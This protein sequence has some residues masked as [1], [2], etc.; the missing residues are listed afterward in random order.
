MWLSVSSKIP[1]VLGP[2]SPS[3]LQGARHAHLALL[4]TTVKGTYCSSTFALNLQVL[5]YD[6]WLQLL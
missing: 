4:C 2:V 1:I 5:L 6:Q 3:W